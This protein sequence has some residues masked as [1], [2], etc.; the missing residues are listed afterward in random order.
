[1]I[2]RIGR[3]V[4]LHVEEEPRQELEPAQT[5]HRHLG[6]LSARGTVVKP[7]NVT[8]KNAKVN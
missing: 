3:N 1:M 6:E 4:Q 5:L 2:G 7:K 8:L